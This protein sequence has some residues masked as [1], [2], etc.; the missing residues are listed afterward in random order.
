[1]TPDDS[2]KMWINRNKEFE[3]A[4]EEAIKIIKILRDSA[5]WTG[6]QRAEIDKKIQKLEDVLIPF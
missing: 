5:Q 3:E 6:S 4:I 2:L 1:M